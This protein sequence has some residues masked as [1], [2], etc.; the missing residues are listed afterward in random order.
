MLSIDLLLQLRKLRPKGVWM[1][2]TAEGYSG[3][4][5]FN[6][7]PFAFGPIHWSISVATG[8][9]SGGVGF[10]GK[11]LETSGKCA[12]SSSLHPFCVLQ[13][14]THQADDLRNWLDRVIFRKEVAHILL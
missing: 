7:A 2:V 1:R 11:P 12:G 13:Q 6:L 14:S 4:K 3:F 5:C 8:P 10:L 9:C